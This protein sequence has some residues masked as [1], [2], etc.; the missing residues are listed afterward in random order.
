MVRTFIQ[1]FALILV[2]LSSFFLIRGNMTLKVT[3]LVHLSGTYFDYNKNLLKNLCEQKVD[4][5][6]G[7][8]LLLLS[9]FFQMLNFL[10]PMRIGDFGVNIR[11]VFLAIAVSAFLFLI[12][13]SISCKMSS[14][15]LYEATVQIEQEK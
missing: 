2:L 6:V 12:S 8:A 10:W 7:G 5:S 14:K 1:V 13:L 15:L 11:G 9:F 3:D 4:Y